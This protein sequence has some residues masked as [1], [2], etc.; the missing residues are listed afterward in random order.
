MPRVVQAGECVNKTD[1]DEFDAWVYQRFAEIHYLEVFVDR[2]ALT[3]PPPGTEGLSPRV[4][5]VLACFAG[6]AVPDAEADMSYF[7][8]ISRAKYHH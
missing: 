1:A 8:P 5:D 6:L 7:F 2:R 3:H 4:R